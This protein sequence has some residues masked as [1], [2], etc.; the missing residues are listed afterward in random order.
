LNRD[1]DAISFF[2]LDYPHVVQELKK[3]KQKQTKV[4]MKHCKVC[5]SKKKHKA[6][7]SQASEEGEVKYT[8]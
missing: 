3:R 2:Y 1:F 8:F 4:T 7:T 5:V 6:Q